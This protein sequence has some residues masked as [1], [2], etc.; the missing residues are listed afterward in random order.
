[1][2]EKFEDWKWE[3]R[4]CISQMTVTH[5]PLQKEKSILS[6]GDNGGGILLEIQTKSCSPF[7]LLRKEAEGTG[8]GL[9]LPMILWKPHGGELKVSQLV[10]KGATIYSFY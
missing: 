4:S 1:M 10:K 8:L 3:V 6:I 5:C 7:S 2:R 9:W